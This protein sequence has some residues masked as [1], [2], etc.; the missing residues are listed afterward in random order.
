[1]AVVLIVDDEA[2]IRLAVAEILREAGATVHLAANG[3]QA[4]D[5]LTEHPEIDLLFTDVL[6][7]GMSGVELANRAIERCPALRVVLTTG[8]IGD[9]DTSRYPVLRKPW[10]ANEL[11]TLLT[12]DPPPKPA[13]PPSS[14]R[15]PARHVL[16]VEDD[17]P[18][19]YLVARA[20]ELRGIR[21]SVA[22]RGLDALERELRDPADL[23]LLDMRLPDIPGR[24]VGEHLRAR[25]PLLPIITLTAYADDPGPAFAS[26]QFRKPIEPDDL[27]QMIQPHF[28]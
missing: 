17:E 15:Q 7:P 21:V 9:E 20:L 19:S 27:F 2:L 1:M 12:S 24:D 22:H 3:Q 28:H 26:A 10:D 4:L 25:R 11:V 5:I 14:N 8:Y 23:L 18:F 13:S 16:V 6:M